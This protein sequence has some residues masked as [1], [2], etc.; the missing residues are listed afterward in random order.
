MVH[1]GNLP[2][3]RQVRGWRGCRDRTGTSRRHRE[4]GCPQIRPTGAARHRRTRRFGPGCSRRNDCCR[5]KRFDRC[6]PVGSSPSGSWG[7]NPS[8]D[9]TE[10]LQHRGGLDRLQAGGLGRT[11]TRCR[12]HRHKGNALVVCVLLL[13]ELAPRVTCRPGDQAGVVPGPEVDSR[14]PAESD[15]GCSLLGCDVRQTRVDADNSVAGTQRVD[16]VTGGRGHESGQS[17][18]HQGVGSFVTRDDGGVE[19]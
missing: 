8:T 19:A 3:V 12:V 18:I 15:C 6:Q 9:L 14:K 10:R 5:E 17:S 13:Y 11:H 1:N 7:A 16:C 2:R 4:T